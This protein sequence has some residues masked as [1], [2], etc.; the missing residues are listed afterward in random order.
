MNIGERIKYCRKKSGLTQEA[1]AKLTKVSTMTIR[2]WEKGE[3]EPTLKNVKLLAKNLKTSVEYLMC[4]TD[5]YLPSDSETEKTRV[6]ELIEKDKSSNFKNV[7]LGEAEDMLIYSNGK[8]VIRLTNTPA[9]KILFDNIV[10]QMLIAIE[11]NIKKDNK[12]NP[13]EVTQN[14]TNIHHLDI[15]QQGVGRDAIITLPATVTSN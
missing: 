3:R 15:N 8:E 14:S 13:N 2:R 7:V 5:E 9:N 1:L 10:Y 6:R 11:N 12:I 4:M